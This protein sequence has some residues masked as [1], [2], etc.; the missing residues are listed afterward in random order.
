MICLYVSTLINP[1]K[2][3]I[4]DFDTYIVDQEQLEQ[5]LKVFD[6]DSNLPLQFK[7][8][9]VDLV[10]MDPMHRYNFKEVLEKLTEI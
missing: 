2:F 10:R 4:Y 7:Q 5:Y 6:R 8:F 9:I 3:K 1:H